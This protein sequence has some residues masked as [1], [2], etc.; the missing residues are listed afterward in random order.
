MFHRY[1]HNGISPA[2]RHTY[3][4]AQQS[5]LKF[6]SAIQ[7]TP[8]PTHESTLLLFVTHLAT[9]GLSHTSI[10]VYRSAI[11]SMHVA[12][13]QHIIFNQQLTPRLQQVLKGIQRTQAISKAP[14]IRRPI[15]LDIMKAI[16]NLLLQKDTSYD[17]TM[18]WAACSAKAAN[19]SDTYIQM[20]GRWKSN[21]YKLYI[22]TPPQEIANLSKV[23][24][25][26]AK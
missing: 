19:M 26:G 7:C 16:L 20:L 9:S 5:Y 12:T 14:R 23:L 22:Q 1:Y 4:S 6:C 11:R 8:T 17:N 25:A 10:K 2:T 3:S 15:T 18:M 13:G 21:A 24:A